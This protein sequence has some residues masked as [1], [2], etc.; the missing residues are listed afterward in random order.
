MTQ[1]YSYPPYKLPRVHSNQYANAGVGPPTSNLA[2]PFNPYVMPPKN[3]P[4]G[5]SEATANAE[6]N[7]TVTQEEA[8]VSNVYRLRT[9]RVTEGVS[10]ARSTT[11]HPRGTCV[12]GGSGTGEISRSCV[13]GPRNG[14]GP[15]EAQAT[16]EHFK[17]STDL[18][19]ETMGF[20]LIDW[21]AV[22]L[23]AIQVLRP[24]PVYPL[25]KLKRGTLHGRAPKVRNKAATAEAKRREGIRVLNEELSRYYE[26]PDDRTEWECPELLMTGKRGHECSY[27]DDPPYPYPLSAPRYRVP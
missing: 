8:A 12:D 9:L 18:I 16:S 3:P 26:L 19:C 14:R 13:P 6:T 24:T 1:A 15:K 22:A 4:G 27:G 10:G 25:P 11:P 23:E 2:L 17:V 21:N 5:S 20:G 7:P